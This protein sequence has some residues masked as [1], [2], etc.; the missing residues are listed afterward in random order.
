MGALT[1]K[2]IQSDAVDARSQSAKPAVSDEYV[3]VGGLGE[4]VYALSREHGEVEWTT[5]RDGALSDSSPLYHDGRV[6]IGSGGGSVYA[7]DG[8]DGSVLWKHST[9]SAV[10]SSPIVRDGTLYVGREDG[11][12]LAL[13]ADDG[14]LEW[15]VDL[16][17][18]IFTDVDYSSS[19]ELVYVSTRGGHLYA[20]DAASGTQS[21]SYTIGTDLD[22]SAPVV[23]DDSGQVYYAA[24]EIVALG[25]DSGDPA[26]VTNF[27]G[28]NAGSSPV[29]DAGRVYAAGA[30]GKVYALA[31]DGGIIHN[32][33]DWV[34]ETRE[35]FASDPALVDGRLLVASLDGAL[36]VLDAASGEEFDCVMLPS[37]TRSAPVIADDEIFIGSR[38]GSVFAFAFA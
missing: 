12:M 34:F 32:D 35:T 18:P 3:Y 15:T 19:A 13:D 25:V 9:D 5:A 7:L 4:D 1:Q 37:E 29:F 38:S 36:Y 20:V 23:D 14:S 31:S 28:T 11:Y 22:S 17:A 26:W 30:S 6:Y 2:W 10:V 33:P 8:S 16:G 24:N 27:Y 21:W